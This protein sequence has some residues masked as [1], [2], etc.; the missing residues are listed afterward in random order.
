MEK[1]SVEVSNRRVGSTHDESSVQYTSQ[2]FS[3]ARDSIPKHEANVKSVTNNL[4]GL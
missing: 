3:N 2:A 4:Q 1:N